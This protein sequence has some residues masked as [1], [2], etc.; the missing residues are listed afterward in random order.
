MHCQLL[1]NLMRKHGLG[2]LVDTAP[3]SRSKP[4]ADSLDT[5]ASGQ[6]PKLRATKSSDP[7]RGRLEASPASAFRQLLV[8]TVLITDMGLHFDWMNKLRALA[9]DVEKSGIDAVAGRADVKQLICQALIKCGDISNPVSRK[10]P[11]LGLTC[12]DA[13][14]IVIDS[15]TRCIGALVYS[16]TSRMVV[17]SCT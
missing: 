1:L 7:L 14:V 2:H 17:P 6:P 12:T 8:Q 11:S 3:L 9:S 4:R 13:K 10:A 16:I 5:G 15:S